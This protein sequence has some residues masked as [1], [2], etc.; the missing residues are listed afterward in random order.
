MNRVPVILLL[1]S[2]SYSQSMVLLLETRDNNLEE[3]GIEV[4]DTARENHKHIKEN[5]DSPENEAIKNLMVKSGEDYQRNCC[6]PSG[7][8]KACKDQSSSKQTG[9][10]ALPIWIQQKY[11][12]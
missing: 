6:G 9:S 3:S 2:F 8:C 4:K 7:Y 1:L 11:G 5:I 12:K 10:V